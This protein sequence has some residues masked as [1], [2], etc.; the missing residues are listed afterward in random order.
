MGHEL[1][2][3]FERLLI[4]IGKGEIVV[5]I[6]WLTDMWAVSR[7]GATVVAGYAMA[8]SSAYFIYLNKDAITLFAYLVY[9]ETKDTRTLS[10]IR[11][12]S[13]LMQIVLSLAVI[14]LL[15]LILPYTGLSAEAA[16][17]T[18]TVLCI[19][20]FGVLCDTITTTNYVYLRSNGKES[21][22]GNLRI[23]AA[24][25]NVVLDLIC[26]A[27]GLGISC[28]IGATVICE[29]LEMCCAMAI[30]GRF[31]KSKA[32]D[33]KAFG[34]KYAKCLSISGMQRSRD[35]IANTIATFLGD[36][37]YAV[38]GVLS[39]ICGSLEFVP[40]ILDTA[41]EICYNEFKERYRRL[42]DWFRDMRRASVRYF[43]TYA[44]F[45]GLVT[46]M[47]TLLIT[48]RLGVSVSLMSA[49]LV[50]VI[51]V[52]V[53]GG[54]VQMWG[55]MCILDRYNTL[56]RLDGI[57]TVGVALCHGLTMLTGNPY[58]TYLFG[59]VI[60]CGSSLIY[61]S[62]VCRKGFHQV[63]CQMEKRG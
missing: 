41:T 52:T 56:I 37:T 53:A 55:C 57:I 63:D 7:L 38:Y 1:R 17:I 12:L 36:E 3:R 29:F 15:C 23:G 14:G 49:A 10:A 39:T 4:S 2:R 33:V 9:G 40:C 47:L 27:A 19:R 51:D 50:L 62:M 22:A 48:N 46:P 42:Q 24:I 5:S 30:S 61:V 31:N 21:V 18:L 6:L 16:A 44:L 26:V 58:L 11:N 60:P 13:A 59:W 25:G 35:A 34:K 8:K 43:I 20:S 45:V 54:Q 28:I 32:G